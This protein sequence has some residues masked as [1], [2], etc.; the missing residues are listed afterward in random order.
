M[1]ATDLDN[2]PLT[3][4]LDTAGDSVFA[5]DSRSGQ[6]R[7]KA[8]LDHET[9]PSYSV[10]VTATDPSGASDS[11]DVTIDVTDVDEPLTLTGPSTVPYEENDTGPVATYRA[12]DP[13]RDPIQWTVDSDAFT[14]SNGVLRFLIP[15]DYEAASSYTVTVE[16]SAGSHTTRQTVTVSV[17]NVNE[18]PKIT[19]PADTAITYTENGTGPVATY[20]ATDPERDP[21]QWTV[22]SDAF[23]IS[24]GV[25]RFL[26]P[27]DYEAASSYTVTVEASDGLL[28]IR[29]S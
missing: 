16:A 1:A 10:T 19:R 4:S 26:I 3:Y 12:T 15:P 18:E 6:L 7:T 5:I 8:E 20:R 2:D 14:I 24:N 29:C 23:T 27:P 17:T 22:D 21:I 28:R 13:E 25:L 11:I 9:T